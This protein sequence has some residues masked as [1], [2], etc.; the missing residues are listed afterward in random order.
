[1]DLL[2]SHII[3]GS[4]MTQKHDSRNRLLCNDETSAL[5][6]NSQASMGVFKLVVMEEKKNSQLKGTAPSIT[7]VEHSWLLLNA[8]KSIFEF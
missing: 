5:I 8:N 2:L 3:K 6:N 7:I 1:M 4:P